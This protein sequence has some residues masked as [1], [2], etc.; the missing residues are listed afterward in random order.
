MQRGLYAIAEHFVANNNNYYYADTA[1]DMNTVVV[2]TMNDRSTLESSLVTLF[3]NPNDYAWRLSNLSVHS[4]ET[5]NV[6]FLTST[7][8]DRFHA[9]TVDI[10]TR[11]I[12]YGSNAF[13]IVAFSSIFNN[14]TDFE[15]FA[16]PPLTKRVNTIVNF[17]FS[18]TIYTVIHN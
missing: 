4:G 18:L 13:G 2:Y 8:Y 12:Y 9:V 3:G 14:D 6:R 1:V 15:Y 10:Q 5:I 16:A 17:F 7:T 11:R